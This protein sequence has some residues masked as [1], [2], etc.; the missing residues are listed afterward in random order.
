MGENLPT[1]GPLLLEMHFQTEADAAVSLG[2][3]EQTLAGYRKS[4]KGPDHATL[5][6]RVVYSRKA[7]RRWMR[8]GGARE[9]E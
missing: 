4:G 2:I 1:L 7:L 3:T 6:R 5:A 8:R 9:C